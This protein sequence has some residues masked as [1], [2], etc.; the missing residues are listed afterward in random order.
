MP[1]FLLTYFFIMQ[2]AI[3][4]RTK[5]FENLNESGEKLTITLK[6]V[7]SVLTRQ[8]IMGITSSMFSGE[9][10]SK[11]ELEEIKSG[12]KKMPIE[13]IMQAIGD[14]IAV[15]HEIVAELIV[16]W[17]AFDEKGEKLPITADMV[18]LVLGD[19]NSMNLMTD[20]INPPTKAENSQKQNSLP[21]TS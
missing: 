15:V 19:V 9:K 14:N 18:G 8:K 11:E 4:N 10:M 17:D 13:K 5:V 20:A 12:E 3:G 2:F 21:E 7:V 1:S 6:G 16:D